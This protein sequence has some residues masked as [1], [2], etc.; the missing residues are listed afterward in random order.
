MGI[1]D[2][3]ANVYANGNEYTVRATTVPATAELGERIEVALTGVDSAGLATANGAFTL[4][5]TGLAAVGKLMN[6]VLSGLSTLNGKA[7]AQPAN[8][9]LPWTVAQDEELFGKWLA[10]GG[11]DSA[12]RVRRDLAARFGRTEGSIRARLLKLGCDPD[13][14]GHAYPPPTEQSSEQNHGQPSGPSSGPSSGPTSGP[15]SGQAG[16]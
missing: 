9:S 7:S 15:T 6:Q 16:S 2:C 1:L 11:T 10:A 12:G 3:R 13:A 14:P 8:A 5:A 4:S